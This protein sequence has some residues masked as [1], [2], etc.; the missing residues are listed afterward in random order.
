M[1]ASFFAC[2]EKDVVQTCLLHKKSSHMLAASGL[3]FKINGW[4]DADGVD[5]IQQ[6]GIF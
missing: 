5:E 4:I 2:K 1:L 6:V 3:R